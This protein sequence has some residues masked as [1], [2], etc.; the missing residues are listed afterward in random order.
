MIIVRIGLLRRW[1]AT[2]EDA[3]HFLPKT[4]ARHAPSDCVDDDEE[5]RPDDNAPMQLRD[6]EAEVTKRRKL[7]RNTM[8]F[9]AAAYADRYK[10]RRMTFIRALH[11][12]NMEE[13]SIALQRTMTKVSVF[14]KIKFCSITPYH[15]REHQTQANRAHERSKMMQQHPKR[16]PPK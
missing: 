7:F 16:R 8:G 6:A 4:L 13:F 15:L 5:E 3:I 14:I 9:T 12:P 1:W 11:R 2:A 10:L